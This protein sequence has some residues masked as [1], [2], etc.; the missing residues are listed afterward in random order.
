MNIT[1]FEYEHGIP[2]NPFINAGA[3]NVTDAIIS[4]YG[5]GIKAA[6]E[7][8]KFIKEISEEPSIVY[9]KTV[10]TSEMNTVFGILLLWFPKRWGYVFGHL[11]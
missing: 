8:S 4:Y 10:A 3:I 11:V 9:S 7:I 1:H 5:N 2:R 6:D